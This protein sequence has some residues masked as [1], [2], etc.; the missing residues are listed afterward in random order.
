ME[1]RRKWTEPSQKPKFAPPV[2]KLDHA[3]RVQ[4]VSVA[5]HAAPPAYLVLIGQLGRPSTEMTPTLPLLVSRTGQIPAIW[6]V[7]SRSPT[8]IVLLVPSVIAAMPIAEPPSQI[9]SLAT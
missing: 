6:F 7:P 3:Y 2:C 9:C 4:P 5:Q 8:R 1:S